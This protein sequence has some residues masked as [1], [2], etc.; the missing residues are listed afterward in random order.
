MYVFHP[1]CHKPLVPS[2]PSFS[3]SREYG[4]KRSAGVNSDVLR[5]EEIKER[6]RRLF[7]KVELSV[8][9]YDTAWVAMVPSPHYSQTPCF[10]GCVSWILENQLKDGS[11]GLSHQSVRLLKD[12]MS[13]TLACILAL[14]RW[15]VGEKQIN[16]GLHFL[17]SNFNSVT[18]KNQSSPIGFDITFPGMLEYANDLGLK[19]PVE[20]TILDTMIKNKTEDIRRL[21]EKNS[22]ESESYLAYLSEGMGDLQ[23]WNMVMKY[24]RNNGSLFN[25]PSTTAASLNHILNSGCLN[26]LSDLL[27]KFGNAVPTIYPLDMYAHLCMVDTLERLGI[28]RHFKQEIKSVLDET[29]RMMNRYSWM[30][31]LV[32]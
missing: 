27:E 4:I 3:A 23:N 32:P 6:I 14:K 8:S 26:Y 18:D 17:K 10:S 28:D 1:N 11:W 25:S 30:W 2:Y 5:I 31:I 12:D 29:Y 24:Q 19:L 15:G 22:P 20:Q 13:S 16:K 9:A 21:S 7:N